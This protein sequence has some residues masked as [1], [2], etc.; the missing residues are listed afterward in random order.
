MRKCF[1]LADFNGNSIYRISKNGKVNLL[2]HN[3]DVNGVN[4]Q[5]D[6]PAEVV[7]RGNELIIV[8]MDMAWATPGLAIKKVVNLE[9]FLYVLDL[10]QIH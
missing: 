10:N 1:Y 4:G 5:L 8:N 2:Y 9:H 3:E 6:Q 7:L